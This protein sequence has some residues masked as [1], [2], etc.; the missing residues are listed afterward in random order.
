MDYLA[1]IRSFI[2]G[3]GFPVLLAIHSV[4][5]LAGRSHRS[6]RGILHLSDSAA[7]GWG[8]FELG[9]ALGLHGFFFEWYENHLLL[10]HAV[11]AVGF[12][13]FVAGTYIVMT[14]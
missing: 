11:I 7:I 2:L 6:P 1:R 5:Y 12:L 14:R 10:K 8:V 13:M 3:L 9:M 4:F